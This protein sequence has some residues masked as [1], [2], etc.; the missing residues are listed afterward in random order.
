MALKDAVDVSAMDIEEDNI[1][2]NLEEYA[3]HGTNNLLINIITHLKKE[4]AR[5]LGAIIIA[6]ILMA[7]KQSGAILMIV[8][9]DGNTVFQ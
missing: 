8:K 4:Q 5:V 1:G 2:L 6:E 3:K 9:K 7:K